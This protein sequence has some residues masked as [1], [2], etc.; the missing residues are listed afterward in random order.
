MRVV[1][2]VRRVKD[3]LHIPHTFI[4]MASAFVFY[5]QRPIFQFLDNQF[6][7]GFFKFLDAVYYRIFSFVLLG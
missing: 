4:S 5:S 7:I 3:I 2:S 1:R 6:L